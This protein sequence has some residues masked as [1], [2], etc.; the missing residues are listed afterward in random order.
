MTKIDLPVILT[1]ADWNNKKGVIAKMAGETGIGAELA[2]VK[3]V[4]D[5]I[6]WADLDPDAA[7]IKADPKTGRQTLALW[8]KARLEV[9]RD[10]YPKV[11]ALRKA[12]LA[13][14]LLA[15][16]IQTKWKASKVIPSSS[17]KHVEN[18]ENAASLLIVQLKNV[19]GDWQ[20]AKVR[21]SVAEKRLRDI[22]LQRIKPY[23]T[24]IK[25]FG[26]ALKK[27]PT[28][29]GF[30]G[31]AKTGFYQNIRGLSTALERSQND[32]LINWMGPNWKPMAQAG[33]VPKQNSEVLAKVNHVLDK[34][35]E[36]ERLIA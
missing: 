17:R 1:V 25:E 5:K 18:M 30:V 31:G 19:D 13:F 34:V 6:V 33:Y 26:A 28:V 7:M 15:G 4:Y 20:K 3:V 14:N 12:L 11:E 29:D 2:K 23:M 36:L 32:E 10:H 22:A 24:S 21:I 8:E 35:T 9:Q 27:D 16:R